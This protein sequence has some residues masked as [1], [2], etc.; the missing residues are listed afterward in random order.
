M[1]LWNK[2]LLKKSNKEKQLISFASGFIPLKS[3]TILKLHIISVVVSLL[4]GAVTSL[5]TLHI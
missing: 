4:I 2:I 5:K 3:F 1:D